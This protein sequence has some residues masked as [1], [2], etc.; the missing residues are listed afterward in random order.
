[1]RSKPAIK[2]WLVAVRSFNSMATNLYPSAKFRQNDYDR[3]I[4]SINYEHNLFH[5]ANSTKWM[6]CVIYGPLKEKKTPFQ[7]Y[8]ELIFTTIVR[9]ASSMNLL[10]EFPNHFESHPQRGTFHLF[11][12]NMNDINIYSPMKNKTN[13]IDRTSQIDRLLNN[14]WP[15]LSI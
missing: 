7:F 13:C 14:L 1:M 2:Q 15:I 3:I 4:K 5:W 8:W 11:I 6:N 12:E 9:F 10:F